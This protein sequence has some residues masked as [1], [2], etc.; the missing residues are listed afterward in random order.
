M[1]WNNGTEAEQK[2]IAAA[3]ATEAVGNEWDYQN[4]M[5]L[6]DDPAERALQT[7]Q[8]KLWGGVVLVP[9]IDTNFRCSCSNDEPEH[10]HHAEYLSDRLNDECTNLVQTGLDLFASKVK[11]QG[12]EFYTPN[13]DQMIAALEKE[14]SNM[15]QL[16]EEISE[17]ER[18]YDT[19]NDGG[20]FDDNNATVGDGGGR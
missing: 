6:S 19:E 4:Q 14:L 3:D 8:C 10:N 17:H 15:K 7:K 12:M 13:L 18:A 1:G 5:V 9:V 20:S 2:V 16:R 11:L